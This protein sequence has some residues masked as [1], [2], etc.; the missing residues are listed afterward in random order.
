MNVNT[1]SF[2]GFYGAIRSLVVSASLMAS[3]LLLADEPALP[4]A[5]L[6]IYLTWTTDPTSSMVVQWISQDKESSASVRYRPDAAEDPWSRVEAEGCSFPEDQPYYV[7]RA[8]LTDLSPGT[9]YRFAIE[10]YSE[11][12]LFTTMP[13]TLASPLSFVVGGDTNLSDLSLFDETNE[14]A[15][16]QNPSFVVIGGDLACA[17]SNNLKKKEDCSRW[18]AWL[19]H[20]SHTMKTTDG[21]IIPLLVTIGNHEVKGG[22]GQTPEQ[23]PF[24][25]HLFASPGKQGYTVLRFG[26]YLSIY[27]LDSGHTH[28]AGGAQSQW[29][30]NEMSKDIFILH[31]IAVYHVPAYPNVRPYRNSYSSSV[32]RHFV[33]V[34]DSCRLHI[35]F[36][37]HDHAYKRTHP[38]LCD[39]VDPR[40]V[41][42]IGNGAWG[43]KAR[44]P[45]KA[46]HTSYL[47]KAVR[48]RQFCTVTLSAEARDVTAITADGSIIDHFTQP[49]DSVA[50]HRQNEQERQNREKRA[51]LAG[52]D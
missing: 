51:F 21:T 35:A 40:G 18:L 52:S 12:H 33:P 4:K 16:L 10:G 27:L 29:L 48:A 28:P 2:F 36:E 13:S 3:W 43:T 26:H 19:S 22:Y 41:V 32:R 34:F 44:A 1:E 24:F 17:A 37:N 6:A 50:A 25:Y 30:A 38:L 9:R 31:R 45:K 20:W 11:D 14:Q 7:H 46:S 49:V 47:K 15:A 42:Y 39:R 5:P 23:A 8:F